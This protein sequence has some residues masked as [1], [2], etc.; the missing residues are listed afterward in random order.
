[1]IQSFI[2]NCALTCIMLN[3][4]LILMYTNNKNIFQV[5]PTKQIILQNV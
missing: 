2:K 5:N 3:I 4:T 1:M